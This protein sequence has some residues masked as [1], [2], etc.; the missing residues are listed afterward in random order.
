[1]T[2]KKFYAIQFDEKDG[3]LK[4]DMKM[5]IDFKLFLQ[6]SGIS[7]AKDKKLILE[8]A[9]FLTFSTQR[10]EKEFVIVVGT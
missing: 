9:S 2:S 6:S 1:M 4:C 7:D 5:L 10:D 8:N 3:K